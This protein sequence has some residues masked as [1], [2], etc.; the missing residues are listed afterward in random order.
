MGAAAGAGAGADVGAGTDNAGVAAR[1]GDGGGYLNSHP[2]LRCRCRRLLSVTCCWTCVAMLTRSSLW[3]QVNKQPVASGRVRAHATRGR[4]ILI[5]LDETR[6]LLLSTIAC[7]TAVIKERGRGHHSSRYA[8][9]P[10][11]SLQLTD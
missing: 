11:S 6:V 10:L 9:F 1:G 8:V 4:A 3:G 2:R 5:V 7:F